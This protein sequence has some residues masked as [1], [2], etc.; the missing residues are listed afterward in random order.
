MRQD[1]ATTVADGLLELVTDGTFP[2]GSTLPS[3]AEIAQRF[4]VSR[5]T[6]REAIRSLASTNVIRV[7]QGRSSIINPADQWSPLDPGLLKARGKA[8]G[9]PLRLPKRLLEARR[10]VEVGIAELAAT[11]RNDEH[12]ARMAAFVEQMRDAH[13][14]TDVPRFVEADLA[15]HTTLFEA[16]DNVFLDA[17]FKPLSSVLRT[18]RHETSSVPEIRE[19]AIEW[20]AKILASVAQGDADAARE[21]MR[22]HLIQTEDDTNHFLGEHGVAHATLG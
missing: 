22:R 14:H 12:L 7:Q 21:M 10:T 3:E 16:V 4:D 11:R 19:H 18:L 6:V 2:P 17:L 1:R 20:H 8:S 15:F 13:Q 5:L 9:E